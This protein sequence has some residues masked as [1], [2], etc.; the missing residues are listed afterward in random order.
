[1][2]LFYAKWRGFGLKLINTVAVETVTS[3]IDPILTIYSLFPVY[4]DGVWGK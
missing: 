1:M 3:A 2:V 4:L